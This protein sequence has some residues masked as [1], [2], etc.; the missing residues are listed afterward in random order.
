MPPRHADIAAFGISLLPHAQPYRAYRRFLL[1][2]PAPYDINAYVPLLRALLNHLL[3]H[4]AHCSDQKHAAAQSTAG[5]PCHGQ[6]TLATRFTSLQPSPPACIEVGYRNG[7]QM[8]STHV[9]HR[10]GAPRPPP[11]PQVRMQQRPRPCRCRCRC[12]CCCWCC[13]SRP[14]ERI[15]TCARRSAT[16]AGRGQEGQGCA[17]YSA[18]AGAQRLYCQ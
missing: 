13:R 16:A 6:P 1:S 12:C 17:C 3:S 4:L 15:G 8:H 9:T 10:P 14:R 18:D 7:T 2:V 11:S 5:M